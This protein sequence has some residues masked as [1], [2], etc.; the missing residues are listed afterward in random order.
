MEQEL[1]T[2]LV[3]AA[4]LVGAAAGVYGV[5]SSRTLIRLLVSIELLFNAVILASAYIGSIVGADPG[6]YSLLLATIVLTIA[7]IAIV[8]AILVL[9]YRTKGSLSA[10]ALREVKG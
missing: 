9:V 3:F 8:T 4:T 2:V 1:V 5:T 6:F 10:D 7:E